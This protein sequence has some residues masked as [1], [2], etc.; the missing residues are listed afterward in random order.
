MIRRVLF[1]VCLL[2]ALA[3]PAS[4]QAPP[5]GRITFGVITLNHPLMMYRQYLP[6]TDF[7]SE[8][9]GLPV[10]LVLAR[11]YAT[12]IDDLTSGRID[13]ALLGGFSYIEARE[14]SA[15]VSPLCAVLSPDGTPTHRTIIFTTKARTDITTL[16]DLRGKAFAFAS[17]HST[18]GYLHPLCY[19]GAHGVSK[20]DFATAT[21]LRTHEA[22]VRS[23]TRGNHDAGAISVATFERFA[24]SGLRA[25][26]K[27]GPHPGFVLVARKAGVPELQRLKHLLLRT[28]FSTPAMAALAGRWTPLLRNGFAPVSDHDYA[29]IRTLRDCAITY[30]YGNET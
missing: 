18:S 24:D 22:V 29:S 17:K 1:T 30:G 2:F 21:N 28:D 11:D 9:M 27:T 14:A 3:A 12:I 13:I 25:I 26:A 4:A 23:V 15:E 6:F 19:L 20:Q 16:R 10:E 8:R 5:S 7:L